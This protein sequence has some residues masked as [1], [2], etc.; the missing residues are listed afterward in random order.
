MK[1]RGYAPLLT[2]GIF[3]S[4]SSVSALEV[5][6]HSGGD[7]NGERFHGEFHQT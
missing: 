1:C 7:N 5:E 4:E 6:D 2:T 3:S